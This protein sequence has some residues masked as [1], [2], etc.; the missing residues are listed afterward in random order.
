MNGKPVAA[1]PPVLYALLLARGDADH[2]IFAALPPAQPQTAQ[3]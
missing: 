3:P 1:F 2:P